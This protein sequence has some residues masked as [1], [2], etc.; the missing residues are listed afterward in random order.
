MKLINNIVGVIAILLPLSGQGDAE[1]GSLQVLAPAS[2]GHR[3][4]QN[5]MVHIDTVSVGTG[6]A[7]TETTVRSI[8]KVAY[9]GPQ[10]R[11]ARPTNA[12]LL[13]PLP[14][15][16]CGN[17]NQFVFLYPTVLGV[18]YYR[19]RPVLRESYREIFTRVV[20]GMRFPWALHQNDAA[21]YLINVDPEQNNQFDYQVSM[22]H[23]NGCAELA[24]LEHVLIVSH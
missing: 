14:Y 21:N 10:P 23:F 18:Q 1:L 9:R 13:E 8:E 22:D 19:L 17:A 3:S 11:V 24:N 12:V 7:T 6:F 15:V 5:P 16:Y 4:D 20:A 2:I